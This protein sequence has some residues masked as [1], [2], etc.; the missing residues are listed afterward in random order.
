MPSPDTA[1]VLID[2][3]NPFTFDGAE[4]LT[5]AE[6]VTACAEAELMVQKVPEQLVVHDGPMP[7]NATLKV[8]KYELKEALAEVPWP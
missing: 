1:L 3:I 6:M 7:R 5:Q 2:V 4:D 8:L